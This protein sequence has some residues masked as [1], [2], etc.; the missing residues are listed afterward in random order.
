MTDML[1]LWNDGPARSA[2][3]DFV[4]RVTKD[5]GRDYVPPAARIATFDNDG[6]LWCEYP[7]PVQGFFLTDRVKELAG[8]DPTM[9]QRQPFKAFLEHDVTTLQALG[10]Q[11]IVELM[12]AT[13]TGMTD[14][15]FDDIV[16]GWL[17]KAVHPK[18]G[19]AF[20]QCTYQPQ[21]EL[22]EYLRTNG[23][24]TF[25]VSGG[26][27]EF[28]RAFAEE[29]YGVP[30]EQ[31]VG[32]SSKL[33]FEVQDGRAVLMKVSALDSFDDRDAKP[34]NIGLHIGRR[35]LLACGNS[36]GDLAMMRYAKSGDGARLALLLH[37]DDAEREFA[38]DRDFRV[39]PLAEA[40]DS[41]DDFGITIVS[42]KRDWKTVFPSGRKEGP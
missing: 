18:F 4:A 38:Y 35:P 26:G 25:I 14:E 39:S 1:S 42:M 12:F 5:G 30:P 40:L 6:T 24:K 19:R 2:I 11:G 28:I 9:R 10:K 33:R 22:L 23:F 21:L 32:S 36:D 15:A 34:A 37:H 31:V 13:H 16:R 41:A 29:T 3:V 17:A 8:K 20:T 7:L 27:I